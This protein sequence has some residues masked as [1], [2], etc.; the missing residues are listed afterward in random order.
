MIDRKR[1]ERDRRGWLLEASVGARGALLGDD[2]D[3][4]DGAGHDRGGGGGGGCDEL[5]GR[6]GEKKTRKWVESSWRS[7]LQAALLLDISTPH[8]YLTGWPDLQ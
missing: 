5:A 8:D 4:V 2:T 3:G 6:E 1:D 7:G